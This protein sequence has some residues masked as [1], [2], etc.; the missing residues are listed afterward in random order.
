M[1]TKK[2]LLKTTAKLNTNEAAISDPLRDEVI[3]V[4]FIYN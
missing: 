3:S 1:T 2:V 4:G